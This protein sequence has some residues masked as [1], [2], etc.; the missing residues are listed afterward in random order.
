MRQY[1]S[2]LQDIKLTEAQ[3]SVMCQESAFEDPE[4]MPVNVSGHG[5][6]Q[7]QHANYFMNEKMNGVQ[8]Y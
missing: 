5:I 2:C 1:L 7:F 8:E 6:A 3:F 4:Y